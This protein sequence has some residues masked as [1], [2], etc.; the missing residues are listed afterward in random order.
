MLTSTQIK[1]YLF[2]FIPFTSLLI[3]F[4]LL[5]GSIKFYNI[6]ILYL[7]FVAVSPLLLLIPE[8]L[9]K[10]RLKNF[11]GG[12][13]WDLG[14]QSII[15][16]IGV[17]LFIYLFVKDYRNN[18]NFYSQFDFF[19]CVI[20]SLMFTFGFFF[21]VWSMKTNFFFINEVRIQTE[22]DH[23]VCETGTYAIMRHPGIFFFK[24]ELIFD[25]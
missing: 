19:S 24:F 1:F 23:K 9:M 21:A 12:L 25:F 11:Y 6:W 5:T 13:S 7:N 10:L 4:F 3:L 16:F 2:H 18:F 15:F 14:I 20:S 17:P 22:R 8:E